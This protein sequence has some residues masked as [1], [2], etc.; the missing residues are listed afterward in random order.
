MNHLNL[1]IIFD[2]GL[3]VAEFHILSIFDNEGSSKRDYL[4]CYANSYFGYV[5]PD[6]ARTIDEYD[7]A[8]EF[9]LERGFIKVLSEE[10]CKRD[11]ERWLHDDN[12]FCEEDICTR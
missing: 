11:R 8:I 9:C 2:S 6:S 4:A 12:Q 5:R 10:D 3:N 7:K 1:D